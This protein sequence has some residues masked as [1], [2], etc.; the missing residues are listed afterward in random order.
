MLIR[1]GRQGC[2]YKRIFAKFSFDG[3]PA[4]GRSDLSFKSDIFTM[5]NSLFSTLDLKLC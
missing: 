2:L 4:A 1:R 5:L 3:C